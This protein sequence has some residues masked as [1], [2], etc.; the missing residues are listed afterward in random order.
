MCYF[1]DTARGRERNSCMIRAELT[2]VRPDV[3]RADREEARVR[4]YLLPIRLFVDQDAFEFFLNFFKPMIPTSSINDTK[5]ASSSNASTN[6]AMDAS[7]PTS[8]DIQSV[9]S[10]GGVTSPRSISYSVG[11]RRPSS[12]DDDDNH[13]PSTTGSS[14]AD[15]KKIAINLASSSQ[16]RKLKLGKPVVASLIEQRPFSSWAEVASRLRLDDA[17]I[18]RL[19]VIA[20]LHVPAGHDGRDDS[21]SGVGN[22]NTASHGSV[23]LQAYIQSFECT[24]FKICVD[25]KPKRVDYKGLKNGDYIQLMHLFPLENVVFDF[26]RVKLYGIPGWDR[27]GGELAIQWGLDIAKRQYHRYL[28]GVQPI[29]SFVN[30]G[31]GVADLFIMPM[32]KYKKHGTTALFLFLI[33]LFNAPNVYF[34]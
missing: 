9:S 24:S 6:G 29:R 17:T 28:A 14:D 30:V 19:R 16:L 13:P 32:D 20:T 8:T 25:Y 18:A 26:K 2:N 31:S 34:S 33:P 11:S 27:I 7:S 1:N 12:A 10:I 3:N 5:G 4:L 23:P 21:K 22:S 15:S